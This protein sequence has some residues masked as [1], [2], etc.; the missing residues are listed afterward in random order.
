MADIAQYVGYKSYG[1]FFKAREKY[2][3][4]LEEQIAEIE[5]KQNIASELFIHKLAEYDEVIRQLQ[6][7]IIWN[8]MMK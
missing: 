3:A 4:E 5:K 8:E 2:M 7:Q 6:R 1:G